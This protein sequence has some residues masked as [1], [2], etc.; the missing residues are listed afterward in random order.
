MNKINNNNNKK[1]IKKKKLS[2]S[3]PKL[4]SDVGGITFTRSSLRERRESRVPTRRLG[5]LNCQN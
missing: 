4:D 2:F 3:F 1:K 5:I